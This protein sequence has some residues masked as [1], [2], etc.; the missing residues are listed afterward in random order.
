MAP[1]NPVGYFTMH[2]I[3]ARLLKMEN[4]AKPKLVFTTGPEALRQGYARAFYW[5]E[6]KIY[7]DGIH[8]GMYNITA[9]K[10]GKD[11]HA[12]FIASGI[13]HLVEGNMTAAERIK[14][15]TNTKHWTQDQ[16]NLKGTA[17]NLHC[18][19]YLYSLERQK[20]SFPTRP[21]R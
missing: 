18:Q 3:L 7:K 15:D 9:R 2:Q 16:A 20:E 12:D 21:P 6:E 14:A 13:D 11:H 5:D 19:E 1:G 8:H 17:P 4:I 10:I